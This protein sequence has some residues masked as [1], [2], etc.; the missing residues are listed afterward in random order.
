M[1]EEGVDPAQR[2]HGG[3]PRPNSGSRTSSRGPVLGAGPPPA[4]P[5]TG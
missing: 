1:A 2:V 3:H 4:G 5:G